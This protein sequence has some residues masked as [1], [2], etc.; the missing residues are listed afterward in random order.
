MS[1]IDIA[2]KYSNFMAPKNQIIINNE[3]ILE[4]FGVKT[5][6]ITVEE[7]IEVLPK[8]NF[9]VNDTQLLRISNRLF[10]LNKNVVIKMGYSNTLETVVEGEIASVKSFFPSNRPPYVE[11][12]GQ[13]KTFANGTQSTKNKPLFDLT[14]GK[15]LFSFTSVESTQKQESKASIIAKKTAK[16]L[17]TSNF[18]C[19][20]ECV[21]VPDLKVRELVALNGI[22]K[23]YDGFYYV[24]KVTHKL[25]DTGYTTKFEARTP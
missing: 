10:E 2:K 17:P 9:V 11:V 19:S 22:G 3:D 18:H 12:Y 8:F 16:K 24:E 6:T 23:N 20:G 13:A 21:G 15:T 4:K 14:Y 5:S 1:Q 25:K 7:S